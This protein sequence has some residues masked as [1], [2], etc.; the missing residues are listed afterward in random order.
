MS[1]KTLYVP[2]GCKQYYENAEGWNQFGEIVEEGGMT[3]DVNGDHR[4]DIADVNMVINIMLGK[5]S[6]NAA[7]DVN[8]DSMVDIADVNMVIN[9]MLGKNI[10]D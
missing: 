10:F 8:G 4:V 2:V 9:I 5:A 6:S 7:S 1:N 3:G